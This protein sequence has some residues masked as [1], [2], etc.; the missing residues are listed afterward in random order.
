MKKMIDCEA[1]LKELVETYTNSEKIRNEAQTRHHIINK[2]IYNV[3]GWPE[4]QV[5]VED[6]E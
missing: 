2:I 3:L 6:Y 5:E 4:D 1:A